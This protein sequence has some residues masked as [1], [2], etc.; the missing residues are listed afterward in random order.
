MKF[1]RLSLSFLLVFLSVM[2]LLLAQSPTATLT[3]T[4]SDVSA[5]V[6]P[7]AKVEVT[8]TKTGIS[9]TTATN[10]AG[11]F[12]FPLLSPGTY[13][14]TVE[15]SGFTKYVRDGIALDVAEK[16]DIQV[17]LQP[18]AMTQTVEVTAAA[19]LLETN[20]SDVGQVITPRRSRTYP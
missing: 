9:R 15:F 19:P 4:V 14:L 1:S 10:A 2:P 6:V 8:N 5:A 20:T 13:R 18:G 11:N 12:Q 17:V 7:G 16:P 3:G